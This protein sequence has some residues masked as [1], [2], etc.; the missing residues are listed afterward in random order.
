MRRV[1]LADFGVSSVQ[2]ALVR[3]HPAGHWSGEAEIGSWSLTGSAVGK[4]IPKGSASGSLSWAGSATGRRRRRAAVADGL[5]FAMRDSD[6][7][8]TNQTG[9]FLRDPGDGDFGLH[10]RIG[11]TGGGVGGPASAAGG[12]HEGKR[13]DHAE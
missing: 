12:K 10:D 9:R 8:D 5:V 4:R 6:T 11:R 13:R 3:F 7:G 2:P 1:D